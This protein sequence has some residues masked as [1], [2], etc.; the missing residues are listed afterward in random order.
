MKIAVKDANVFIDMELMGIF[1]LWVQLGIQTLTSS[2]I[3]LEL[4]TGNHGEALAYIATKHI[5]V[6][7]PPLASIEALYRSEKGLSPQDASVLQ[8]AMENDAI[9]LTGD[10]T[11][12]IAAEVRQVECHGSIWILDQLVRRDILPGT[13]AAEKLRSLISSSVAG[14]RYLPRRAAEAHIAKWTM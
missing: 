1:D 2:L 7:N 11:L 5:T 14:I 12:R 6:L 9:L 3:A 8:I 13:V 10:K 4:E